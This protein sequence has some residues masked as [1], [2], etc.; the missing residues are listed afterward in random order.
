MYRVYLGVHDKS[1][2]MA[3]S[4]NGSHDPWESEMKRVARINIHPDFD[5][6]NKLND[7]AV[8]T[9]A[10][11]IE[12]SPRIQIACLPPPSLSM[13]TVAA[14]AAAANRKNKILMVDAALKKSE[15]WIVGWGSM[16]EGGPMV[17]WLRNARLEVFDGALCRD[18]VK[19]FKKNWTI[20]I[21]AG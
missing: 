20:Q 5:A 13:S 2:A 21:C 11:E 7:L 6:V 12:F 15:A 1:T 16:Y 8:I 18:V 19:E 17:E 4:F 14:T 9:L 3:A 10:D